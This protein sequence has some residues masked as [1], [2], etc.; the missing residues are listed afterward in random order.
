[1]ILN[2]FSLNRSQLQLLGS[3]QCCIYASAPCCDCHVT[4]EQVELISKLHQTLQQFR[5]E[6]L[7]F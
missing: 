6:R 7:F 3:G 4:C 1:M 5:T 2:V